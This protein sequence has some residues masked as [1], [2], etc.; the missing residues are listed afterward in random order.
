MRADA[1]EE[2]GEACALSAQ[3]EEGSNRQDSMGV[4]ASNVVPGGVQLSSLD[5]LQGQ[6]TGETNQSLCALP[7]SATQS[8]G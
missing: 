1:R 7:D 6:Q 4:E 5:Q 2:Q 8:T 3:V